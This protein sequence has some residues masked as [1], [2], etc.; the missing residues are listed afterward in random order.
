MTSN[1]LPLVTIA[2]PLYNEE[3]FIL[4]T[5]YSAIN[6]TYKNIEI[7]ISDNC[8]TDCSSEKIIE[9]VQ[10][11]TNVQLIKHPVNIGATANFNFLKNE[12]KGEYFMW[13]GAHDVISK[14]YIENSIKVLDQNLGIVMAFHNAVFFSGTL[15]LENLQG[16]ASSNIDTMS[17]KKSRGRMYAVISNLEFCSAIHGVFRTKILNGDLVEDVQGPD[18]LMLFTTAE[19]GHF[20]KIN[21]LGYYRRNVHLNEDQKMRIKRYQEYKIIKPNKS[22]S[23]DSLAKKHIDHIFFSKKLTFL[24][25]LKLLRHILFFFNKRHK[26]SRI[27]MVK[28]TFHFFKFIP[29]I[30]LPNRNN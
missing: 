10:K 15:N 4:E 6:Q 7:I 1:T 21:Q 25:K 24:D 28:H 22:N 16:D 17:Y 20:K 9:V 23:F 5:V 13:L 19:F 3:K 27:L 14:N 12:A 26:V 8:S 18:N 30:I 29:K 2:I 11:N